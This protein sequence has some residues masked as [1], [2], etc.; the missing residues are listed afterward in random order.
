M[1]LS[2]NR[3]CQP[4]YPHAH[5]SNTVPLAVEAEHWKETR[6]KM[7]S[8][9]DRSQR[10]LSQFHA[11]IHCGSVFRRDEFDGTAVATGIYPCTECGHD[12]PLNIVIRDV[13]AAAI[14]TSDSA[15]S[16]SAG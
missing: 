11:C 13:D 1:P 9:S 16:G 14:G 6:G 8:D 2:L 7:A 10:G 3:Y 5:A 15:P 4:A 12:G